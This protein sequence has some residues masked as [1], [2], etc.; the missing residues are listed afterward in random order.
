MMLHCT[1]KNKK[2]PHYQLAGGHIDEF[3]FLAA[4]MQCST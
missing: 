2:P 1:R 4:G 3:E